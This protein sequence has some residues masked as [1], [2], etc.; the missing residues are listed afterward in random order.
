[1]KSKGGFRR[2]EG[3]KPW[4]PFSILQHCNSRHAFYLQHCVGVFVGLWQAA[5]PGRWHGMVSG[6]LDMRMNFTTRYG[7]CKP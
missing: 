1:M 3:T 6:A 7:A 4:A 2:D 5:A